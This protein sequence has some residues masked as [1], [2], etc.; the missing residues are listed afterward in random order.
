[1]NSYH[2]KNTYNDLLFP[3][4][5]YTITSDG[6]RP[7]GRGF[8][9][10][11]WHEELQFTIVKH[12]KVQAKVNG[13]DHLLTEGDVIF[14]NTDVLHQMTDLEKN[15]SYISINFPAELLAFFPNS[16][17][18]KDFV[19]P[20]LGF[21]H[22]P[23]RIFKQQNQE[24]HDIRN[25]LKEIEQ[26]YFKQNSQTWQYQLSILLCQL[27]LSVIETISVDTLKKMTEKGHKYERALTMIQYIH[28][29]YHEQIQSQDIADSTNISISESTRIFK[30][31][32]GQTPYRFLID[33]RLYRA[34]LLLENSPLN[35]TEIAL[36]CGFLDTSLFIQSFKKKY[37][38]TP[39]KYQQVR[40][41]G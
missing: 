14:I 1:M 24:Y 5:I 8:G 3:F 18:E 40:L 34:S 25:I 41:Q 26:L 21:S 28:K 32:T 15:S 30:K 37:R 39:K 22:F 38:T 23:A 19:D 35:I 31:F 4:E 36:A 7:A 16:R 27:W 10:T 17:M 33:Y 20:Y 13:E 2:E 12:G 9:D 29:N 6:V 11:H